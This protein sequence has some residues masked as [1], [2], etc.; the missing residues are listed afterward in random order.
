MLYHDFALFWIFKNYARILLLSFWCSWRF[1]AVVINLRVHYFKIYIHTLIVREPV[2]QETNFI[3]WDVETFALDRR[4]VL[5]LRADLNVRFLT[6]LNCKIKQVLIVNNNYPWFT[7]HIGI[8]LGGFMVILLNYW[9]TQ[10]SLVSQ[11]FILIEIRFS[12]ERGRTGRGRRPSVGGL[13]TR[14]V[15]GFPNVHFYFMNCFNCSD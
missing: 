12:F 7:F 13:G 6:I 14:S 1:N 9:G 11:L 5:R 3:V 2:F 10:Q 15:H 8:G 4:F